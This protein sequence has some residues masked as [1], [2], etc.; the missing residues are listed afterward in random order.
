MF[1][2]APRADFPKRDLGPL[3]SF[4]KAPFTNLNRN[5]QAHFSHIFIII[6]DASN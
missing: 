3:R 6:I 2:L 5:N 4:P 1:P